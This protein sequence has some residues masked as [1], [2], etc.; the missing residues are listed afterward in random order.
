MQ[1][2]EKKK[3][4]TQTYPRVSGLSTENCKKNLNYGL[5]LLI[6]HGSEIRPTNWT[7][8]LLSS[9]RSSSS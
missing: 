6:E 3:K 1:L 2:E 4:R 7:K 5:G 8:L 9:S